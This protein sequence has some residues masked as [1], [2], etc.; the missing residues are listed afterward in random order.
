[1]FCAFFLFLLATS[2]LPPCTCWLLWHVHTYAHTGLALNSRTLFVSFIIDNRT[3]KS[4]KFLLSSCS[5]EQVLFFGTK[6]LCR[7]LLAAD[8]LLICMSSFNFLELFPR[9]RCKCLLLYFIEFFYLGNNFALVPIYLSHE[10]SKN[11]L[12]IALACIF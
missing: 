11:G 10:L 12:R 2:S 8:I 5:L 1:M 7:V 4:Q 9:G 6:I 3:K